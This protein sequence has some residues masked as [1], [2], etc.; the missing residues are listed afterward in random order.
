MSAVD[1]FI[2]FS[3]QAVTEFKARRDDPDYS[4][5][6][7]DRTYQVMSRM[8]DLDNRQRLFKTTTLAGKTY[9]LFSMII[10][11]NLQAAKDAVDDV[12][13]EWP[14]HIVAIGAWWFDTG[15]QVG[16]EGVY[17]EDGNLT[18]I[19]GTP[20]YPIH[21]QT[22]RLLTDNFDGYDGSGDP[23]YTP[24]TSNAD[25]RPETINRCLGQAD[26]RFI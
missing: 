9:N 2:A 7:D 24:L 12:T 15:L 5:P 11:G 8:H 26:R 3:D 13:A 14:T 10:T 6:M 17:D 25:I 21:A 18:G 4:G 22:W 20:T 19:T 1:L 16:T 23:I